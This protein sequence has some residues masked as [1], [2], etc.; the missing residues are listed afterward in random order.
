MS[1]K[2]WIEVGIWGPDGEGT[3]FRELN[4]EGIKQAA[5]LLGDWLETHDADNIHVV[6]ITDC[7]PATRTARTAPYGD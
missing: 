2:W 4:A 5:G 3:F 6:R 1:K 7:D